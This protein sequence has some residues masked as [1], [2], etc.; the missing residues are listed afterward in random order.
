MD[1]DEAAE[2]ERDAFQRGRREA[3]R[4]VRTYLES[5]ACTPGT[6]LHAYRVLAVASREVDEMIDALDRAT[7]ST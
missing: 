2:R 3:L 5:M 7:A 1:E 6:G 4:E